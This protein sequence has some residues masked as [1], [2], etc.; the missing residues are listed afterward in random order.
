MADS[1]EVPFFE[2]KKNQLLA[3]GLVL[4]AMLPALVCLLQTWNMRV[5]LAD[6]ETV[7]HKALVSAQH[8]NASKTAALDELRSLKKELSQQV[9]VQ[10]AQ[11]A[12]GMETPKIDTSDLVR[13]S[14]ILGLI[15]RKQ[16]TAEGQA[17]QMAVRAIKAKLAGTLMASDIEDLA[18]KSSVAG[19]ASKSELDGLARKSELSGLAKKSELR[20]LARK[21]ALSGLAKKSSLKS[22]ATRREL[23][24]LT[25]GLIFKIQALER[26]LQ[27]QIAASS[28][29]GKPNK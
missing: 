5:R 23:H 3:P 16:L 2:M 12:K 22:L 29:H 8:A 13:R 7:S 1:T 24:V 9:T 10:I 4:V 6:A 20:G 17:Q 21:S 15:T 26:K 19:L 14:E 11:A 25:G 28:P 18:T 27:A